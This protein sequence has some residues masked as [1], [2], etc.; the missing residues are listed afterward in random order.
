[1]TTTRRAWK[2]VESRLSKVFGA[3]RVAL[4]GGNSKITRSDTNHKYL[5]I[6]IKLK[7]KSAIHNLFTK[8]E[9]LAYDEAKV[10][11]LMLK[12]KYENDED[13]LLVMRL[14]DLKFITTEYMVAK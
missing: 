3:D 1:M 14:K 2:M 9:K 10:P 13:T 7:A 8:T 6:E 4:S 5:F 12:K 11:L